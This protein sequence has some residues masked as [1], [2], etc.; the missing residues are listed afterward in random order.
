MAQCAFIR[1]KARL[2]FHVVPHSGGARDFR[3]RKTEFV[4]DKGLTL[5]VN[6]TDL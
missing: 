3:Q 1:R 4:L 5:M 6:I 2:L